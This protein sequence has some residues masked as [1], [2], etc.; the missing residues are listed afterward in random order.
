ML[1]VKRA[2]AALRVDRPLGHW[3]AF[4][5]ITLQSSSL[6]WGSIFHCELVPVKQQ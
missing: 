3:P 6:E 5:E 1:V 2:T 4:W